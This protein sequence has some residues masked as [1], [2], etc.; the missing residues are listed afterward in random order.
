MSRTFLTIILLLLTAVGATAQT[1]ITGT[2]VDSVSGAALPKASVT[3]LRAGRAILFARA[4]NSGHFA[5]EVQTQPGDELQTTCMGYKKHRQPVGRDNV[6]RLVQQAFQLKEVTVQGPPVTQR[7][8]TIVYDLTKYANDRD[9]NLKDVLKKLPGVDIEKDGQIKYKGKAISRFTVEGLDLS[10]GQY[11]KLTDNIR[12]KDVKKAE[13]VE[14]DQPIKALRNRVFTDD[15]GMNIV[16]KDSAR[17]QFFVTLRPYLLTDDPTHVGGD[18]VGMQIGKKKQMETT[19][20][21]DRSGR[22]LSNQFSIFYNAFDFATTADVPK[23]YSAPSLQSPIDEERL[24]RNTSQAYSIDYLT[25]D[26]HDAE[27]SFSVSYNRNVVRQHTQ[28]ISQYFLGGQ[29]PT[30]TTEDRQMT[31]RQDALSMDFN[32]RIN[33]DSHYGNIVVKANASQDDGLTHYTGDMS[34]KTT[35]PELNFTTAISQTFTVGRNTLQWKSTADFHYA[36]DKFSVDGSTDTTSLSAHPYQDELTNNLW[37]TAHSLSWNRQYGKWHRDYQ[38]RLEAENLNVSHENNALLQGGLTPSWYYKDDDW[39]IYFTPEIT[40]KRFTR[41]DANMLLPQGAVSVNRDYGNRANWRLSASYSESTPSW[42]TLSIEHRRTDYRT[43]IDAPDFVPR[44][45]VLISQ[46]EYNYKRAIYQFFSSVKVNWSRNWNNAAMDMII[47]DGNYYYNWIRHDTNSDDARLSANL[48]KG[49]S[50]IHLKTNL[51]LSGNYSNGEQYSAGQSVSYR[52][53]SYGFQPEIIFS[54]SWMEIDYKGDFAFNRSRMDG[55][56]TNTL[57]DWTQRLTLIS[58]INHIDITLSGVLY[59]NELQNS[60]SVNTLLADAKLTW[61]IGKVRASA[62]L[63][64]LFNKKTYEETI[65]SGVGIF[66]NRYW[67][68]PRELMVN[69]Q[70]SL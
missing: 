64:N 11:N 47:T 31:L 65:Y 23:W 68:R 28:N 63:R 22:D 34:Q 57:S 61:R 20:Q 6:I 35:T 43:W 60:P 33:A 14:H 50:S 56:W 49:W 26:R 5:I 39:R 27:N 15:V 53:V 38:V 48:S 10:K 16:L 67:L 59:H 19:A 21:Y 30:E 2:V 29:S 32:H 46:F 36:K 1:A 69:V 12:A 3:L 42:E 8:D 9:N 41:Q 54:P 58:T 44:T 45:R 37:H 25:K 70:F 13:V 7:R 52:Y 18:A 62:T 55:E 40:A 17:D 66:T 51:S 4:D 24:R